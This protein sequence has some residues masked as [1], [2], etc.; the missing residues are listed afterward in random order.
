MKVS[1][2]AET[3]KMDH[4][5]DVCVDVSKE[6]LNVMFRCAGNV[7]EDEF[8]NRTPQIEKRLKQYAE[9]VRE[10]GFV[11]LR[12]ICE[13]TGQYHNKLTRTARRLG[14]LSCY[15]NTESVS[16]LR[17][18]ETND[19]GKTDLKDPFIIATLG[20]LGKTLRLRELPED[21]AT[22]RR[23]GKMYDETSVDLTRVRC[24]IEKLRVEVFCDYSFKK[25]FMYR[26]NGRAIADLYGCNAYRIAKAGKTRFFARMKKAAPRIRIASLNRLWRDVRSSTLNEL[27]QG[28]IDVSEQQFSMFWADFKRLEERKEGLVKQMVELLDKIREEDPK[29]PPPTKNVISAKNLARLLAETGPLDDFQNWRRLMRYAGLNLRERQSG[30]FIGQ[31]KISKRGR[32]L[33]R[34][35]LQEIVLPLVR[36][37]KMYGEYY[38]RKKDQQK[39]PGRKAMVVVMR[40]FLRKFFG[41]YRSNA[42]F[43]IERWFTCHGEMMKKAA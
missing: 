23:L 37:D 11:G 34:K 22:L 14:F 32:R 7:Y 8:A 33:L 41:W 35:I 19:A 13:P 29:I 38:H 1:A 5:V 12:I 2:V 6:K 27:Q 26:G 21:Y 20:K 9:T 15:V 40:Q 30:K 4:V 25:D 3:V 10:H 28:Y 16:K 43:D 17:V 31:R 42:D 18:V 39:M 24:R 36:K